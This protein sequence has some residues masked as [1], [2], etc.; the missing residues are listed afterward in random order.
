MIIT[1]FQEGL[2]ADCPAKLNLFLEILGKRPD[3]FH[4]VETVMVTVGLFDTLVFKEEQSEQVRLQ[5]FDAAQRSPADQSSEPEAPL[6]VDARNL[7]VRAAN[8]L[9]DRTGIARGVSIELHKRIPAAAGLAGGSSDAAAT[10]ASLN[11]LWDLKLSRPD[12]QMIAAELG[13]DIPF[14][15]AESPLALCRGRGELITPLEPAFRSWT[16]IV[17]PPIGLSTAEVFRHCKPATQPVSAEK[18]LEGLKDGNKE[19]VAQNLHNSL[20]EPAARLCPLLTRLAQS[21]E[22]VTPAA[23]QMSGSGTAWFGLCR[24]RLQARQAAGKLNA[25]G[26][27]RVYIAQTCPDSI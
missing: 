16:V 24:N 4:E 18:L 20:Q 2:R 26:V 10:L 6:P 19:I 17:R 11:R 23:H 22:S 5:C 8:L 25:L 14:F 9:K 12:L 27:G 1:P 7:V 21:F 15:L 13:S 3:G